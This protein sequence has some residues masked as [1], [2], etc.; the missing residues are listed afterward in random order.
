MQRDRGGVRVHGP[1]LRY[2]RETRGHSLDE[3]GRLVGVSGPFLSMV[4]TGRRKGVRP[5]VFEAITT[6]LVVHPDVL[7]ALPEA[8][9]SS[10]A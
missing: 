8:P 4:E 10:A 6:A 2:V 5:E 9:A 1:A 3:L 7:R